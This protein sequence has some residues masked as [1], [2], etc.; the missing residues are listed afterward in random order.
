MFYDKC[1]KRFLECR[2]LYMDHLKKCDAL[3]GLLML[4]QTTVIINALS[5]ALV[6]NAFSCRY[7]PPLYM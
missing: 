1:K 7:Y 4:I 6:I 3:H 5:M 2:R